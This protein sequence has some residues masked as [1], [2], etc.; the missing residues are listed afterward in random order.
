MYVIC[1]GNASHLDGVIT[2]SANDLHVVILQTVDTFA[3]L[4]AALYPLQGASTCSPVAFNLLHNTNLKVQL[5]KY[6]TP[7]VYNNI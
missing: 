6:T 5:N 3:G 2:K 1:A 7:F 4:T